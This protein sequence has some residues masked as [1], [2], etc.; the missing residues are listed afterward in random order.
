MQLIE[1]LLI[2]KWQSILPKQF[3]TTLTLYE[4]SLTHE[5][6]RKQFH[7]QEYME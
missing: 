6:Q 5:L 2:G 7:S 1:N 4:L 3:G